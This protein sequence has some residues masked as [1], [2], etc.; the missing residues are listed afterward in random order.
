M[1]RRGKE[2]RFR[3]W[4]KRIRSDRKKWKGDGKWVEE[5]IKRSWMINKKNNEG[6]KENRVKMITWKE[7][8]IRGEKEKKDGLEVQNGRETMDMMKKY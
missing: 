1:K 4:R 7:N 3:E 6:D 5:W 8:R 2:I